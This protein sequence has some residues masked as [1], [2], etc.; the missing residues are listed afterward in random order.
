MAP[1][2]NGF[3][4]RAEHVFAIL[5]STYVLL[6]TLVFPGS[7]PSHCVTTNFCCAARRLEKFAFRMNEDFSSNHD[8]NNVNNVNDDDNDFVDSDE[9]DDL[10][11]KLGNSGNVSRASDRSDPD[12]HHAAGVEMQKYSAGI[13]KRSPGGGKTT[14]AGAT[15]R[16]ET[17]RELHGDI[18]S[19]IDQIDSSR[20]LWRDD[21]QDDVSDL[22]AHAGEQNGNNASNLHQERKYSEEA[23]GL[24]TNLNE[25]KISRDSSRDRESGEAD[26]ESE[27]GEVICS[28]CL[29][30]VIR[31]I[32][33]LDCVIALLWN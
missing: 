13:V 12:S 7:S 9:S 20:K 14:E 19:G 30:I 15:K 21:V 5:L 22:E 3:Q 25:S 31:L 6:H 27:S 33:L 32:A 29:D 16:R 28:I 2:F 10:G 1:R 8:V 17:R 18:H 4:R 11:G 24:N 23:N 26:G